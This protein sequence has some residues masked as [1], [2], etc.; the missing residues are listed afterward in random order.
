MKVI[1][2]HTQ[3]K[4]VSTFPLFKGSG[5]VATSLYIK[6]GHELKEHV[7][8]APAILICI[9]GSCVFESEEGVKEPLTNGA[10]VHIPANIKHKVTANENS[11]LLLLK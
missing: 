1:D 2:N 10:Y 9:E 6:K 7:S 4:G 11:T 3:D 5:E 8:K